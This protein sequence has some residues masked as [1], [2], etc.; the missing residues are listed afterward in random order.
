[1]SIGRTSLVP[2]TAEGYGFSG[3]RI[4]RRAAVATAS[5]G[6]TSWMSWAYT[7]L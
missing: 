5:A 1:M 6:P 7:V 3:D 2:S 4:P